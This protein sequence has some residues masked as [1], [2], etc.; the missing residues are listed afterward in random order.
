MW[1]LFTTQPAEFMETY[2]PMRVE[3]YTSVID[4]GGAG[5]HRGGNGL[6]KVYHFLAEGEVSI[7]DDRWLT[8][9][10]GVNGGAPAMRGK[11]WIKRKDGSVEPVRSKCDHQRVFPGDEL[12][13]QT[14][15]GG[16][17]GDPLTREVE[18]V[19][20]DARLRLVSIA[21]A[22]ESY[23]V[24][25]DAKTLKV[26][27]AATTKLREQKKKSR[28]EMKPFDFGP[29]LEEILRRCK[30]ETGLE[31]PKPPVFR[32]HVARMPIFKPA[33]TRTRVV[34]RS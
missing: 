18:R 8:Y 3:Q 25:I 33:P 11:K 31:P 6:L 29:P 23:G 4:S 10:W 34:P 9:Q 26:D 7:H 12:Y 13:Y 2:Y 27:G 20:K 22:H 21:K 28:G 19:E 15:G 32:Q 17:Y 16:G 24:V 30:E 1:P 14:W 5:Y